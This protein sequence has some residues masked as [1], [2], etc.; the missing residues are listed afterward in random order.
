MIGYALIQSAISVLT[1]CL[2]YLFGRVHVRAQRSSLPPSGQYKP[3][4]VCAH[5]FGAHK[6]GYECGA[7]IFDD[8]GSRIGKCACLIYAGPD[9]VLSG[10]WSPSTK[11]K[12]Q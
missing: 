12:V 11:E 3:V 6:D 4:C 8:L 2:G 5:F 10:L 1:L 9:P 7:D